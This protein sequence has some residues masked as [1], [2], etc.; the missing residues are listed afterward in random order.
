MTVEEFE[1]LRTALDQLPELQREAIAL[2]LHSCMQFK[3]IAK[4]QGVTIST[5]QARYRY[6]LD[7]LGSLLDGEVRK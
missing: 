7:K 2:R 6:G 5:V 4:L 3:A 1:V